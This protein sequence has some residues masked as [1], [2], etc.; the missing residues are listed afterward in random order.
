MKNKK[1]VNGHVEF[2]WEVKMHESVNIDKNSWLFNN[3]Q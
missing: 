1:N 3:I 2:L